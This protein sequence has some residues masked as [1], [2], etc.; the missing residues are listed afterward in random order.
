MLSGHQ[1]TADISGH[2]L[3]GT[4]HACSNKREDH[5]MSCAEEQHLLKLKQKRCS[6]PSRFRLRK[7]ALLVCW[8][9]L[10]NYIIII[11]NVIDF[12]HKYYGQVLYITKLI[13]IETEEE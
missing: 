1:R 9:I 3:A 13:I 5:Q 12:F 6:M 2:F 8:W 4:T 10:N 7:V 11:T